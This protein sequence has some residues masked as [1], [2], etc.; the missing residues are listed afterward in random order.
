M[1]HPYAQLPKQAFW[2]SGVA[3]MNFQE[4]RHVC[5]A[6]KFQVTRDMRIVTAGSC[7]AQ[8][9]AHRLQRQGF[10][11]CDYEPAPPP[12]PPQLRKHYGYEIFSARYGNIYTARQLLQTFDRAYGGPEPVENA[13]EIEGRWYDPFRPAIEPKGFASE[14]ELLASRA[15]HILALRRVFQ[16]TDLFIFTLGLTEAWESSIDSFVFPVCPGTAAGRFD[17]ARHRFHNFNFPET[18]ADMEAFIAKLREVN[19]SVRV[20]LTVSP[21]PLTATASGK[22][23]LVATTYSKSVLRAV[24]GD[25]SEKYGFVDYFPSYELI[26]SAPARAMFYDP[27]L[28][29]VTETGVN[30]VMSRFF[31]N[32]EKRKG[33]GAEASRKKVWWPQ[34]SKE[35]VVCEEMLLEQGR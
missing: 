28:R 35:D 23:V 6:A 29:N 4:I 7:F 11:F 13:W 27:N 18:M 32:A 25:L 15:T 34:P 20:L 30:F 9:I 12:L 17:P 24:A 21:V 2:R 33:N 3:D 19:P 1:N 22:H 26:A 5:A 16:E 31:A 10:N 14:T 8:H